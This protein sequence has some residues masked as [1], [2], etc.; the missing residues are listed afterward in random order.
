MSNQQLVAAKQEQQVPSCF[1]TALGGAHIWVSKRIA[2]RYLHMRPVCG[3]WKGPQGGRSIAWDL[4]RPG[5]CCAHSL[6]SASNHTRAWTSEVQTGQDCVKLHLWRFGS[7]LRV[8]KRTSAAASAPTL[9]CLLL[10]PHK[11]ARPSAYV[12][13]SAVKQACAHLIACCATLN[14]CLAFN[15]SRLDRGDAGAVCDHQCD[16]VL[17]RYG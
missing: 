12:S 4:L 9:S 11:H 2:A 1:E 3:Y 15:A 6:A 17:K 14:I 16:E 8:F 7:H 13:H 10:H 5:S